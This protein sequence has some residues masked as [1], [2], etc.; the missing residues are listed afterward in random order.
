[1]SESSS[2]TG[3]VIAGGC[4][5]WPRTVL[6][7]RRGRCLRSTDW[8]GADGP[9]WAATR[10][11]GRGCAVVDGRGCVV[12]DGGGVGRPGGDFRRY[13]CRGRT[14]GNG[15]EPVVR[16][17]VD[18]GSRSSRRS[19]DHGPANHDGPRT[20]APTTPMPRCG[21]SRCLRT[22][23]GLRSSR[24]RVWCGSAVTILSFIVG[25]TVAGCGVWRRIVLCGQSIGRASWMGRCGVDGKVRVGGRVAGCGLAVVDGGG[26]VG[27]KGGQAL[28]TCRKSVTAR[29]PR[30]WHGHVAGPSAQPGT[31]SED[32]IGESTMDNCASD[33]SG[34]SR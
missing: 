10:V 7:R 15:S 13:R 9:V 19:R 32:P 1:M 12:A 31:Q 24:A 3:Y 14:A 34:L 33:T 4:G 27:R 20:T 17:R 2:F 16:P 18:T 22:G 25:A 30:G 29:G 28:A 11:T 26:C 23:A 8:C 5:V 21:L 6:R